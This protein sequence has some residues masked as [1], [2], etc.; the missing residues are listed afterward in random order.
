MPGGA[1]RLGG[2]TEADLDAISAYLLGLPPIANGPFGITDGG[3][4]FGGSDGGA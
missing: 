4:P 3:V 1:A 2:L